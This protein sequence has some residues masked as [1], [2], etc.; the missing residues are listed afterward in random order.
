MTWESGEFRVSSLSRIEL[1]ACSDCL[2]FSSRRPYG[3]CSNGNS[4]VTD[5]LW[6]VHIQVNSGQ[7]EAP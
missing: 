2:G 6:E 4:G 1:H 7:L 3:S 5:V